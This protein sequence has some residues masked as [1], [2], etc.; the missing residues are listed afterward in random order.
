LYRDRQA[1]KGRGDAAE[2]TENSVTEAQRPRRRNSAAERPWRH[3]QPGET[4]SYSLIRPGCPC[5]QRGFAAPT[6]FLCDLCV[7]VAETLRALLDVS[8][9]SV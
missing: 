6:L 3:G 7:S 9:T 2:D 4:L 5:L 8:V 1:H